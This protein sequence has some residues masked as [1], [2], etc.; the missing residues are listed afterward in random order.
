MPLRAPPKGNKDTALLGNHNSNYAIRFA[1][2]SVFRSD[3]N[4]MGSRRHFC[5]AELNARRGNGLLQAWREIDKRGFH[6]N[7]FD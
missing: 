3:T 2:L 1:T 4:G 7:H 5:F 6:V